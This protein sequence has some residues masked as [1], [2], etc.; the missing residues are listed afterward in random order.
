ML[1]CCPLLKA[2]DSVE[3]PTGCCCWACCCCCTCWACKNCANGST[4]ACP[5]P[6]PWPPTPPFPYPCLALSG[7][8]TTAAS[9]CS[10][11]RLWATA[12]EAAILP[13]KNPERAE[14][15][16]TQTQHSSTLFRALSGSNTTLL[17]SPLSKAG[18]APKHS[19]VRST[20]LSVS[21]SC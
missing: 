18:A 1:D 5:R 19:G 13:C 17:N 15:T 10:L 7:L 9:A 3:G 14:H 16:H 4:S 6:F 8:E 2:S 12:E 11:A 21:G 20:C